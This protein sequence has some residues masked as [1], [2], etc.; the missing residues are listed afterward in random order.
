MTMRTNT[1]GHC[2]SN[3]VHSKPRP[4]E[5]VF[6][7]LGDRRSYKDQGQGDQNRYRHPEREADEYLSFSTMPSLIDVVVAV[8]LPP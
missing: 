2:R 1:N 4:S 7:L 5:S 3:H 8:Q 6:E